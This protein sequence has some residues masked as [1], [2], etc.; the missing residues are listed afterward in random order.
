[1]SVSS[2]CLEIIFSFIYSDEQEVE[3]LV[4]NMVAYLRSVRV[5]MQVHPSSSSCAIESQSL[6]S[7]PFLLQRPVAVTIARSALD[8]FIPS[9][10]EKLA[11][12]EKGSD[13]TDSTSCGDGVTYPGVEEIQRRVISAVQFLLAHWDNVANGIAALGGLS[14]SMTEVSDKTNKETRRDD[15][16]LNQTRNNGPCSHAQ[17][18]SVTKIQIGNRKRGRS[19]TLKVHDLTD[20]AANR[21]YTMFLHP[22]LR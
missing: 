15:V 1:V 21:A 7:I 3:A 10:C 14:E 9:L 22:S 11:Y 20:D 12:T 19:S 13:G 2:I 18:D 17:A 5:Q 6:S 16:A 8:G 4:E